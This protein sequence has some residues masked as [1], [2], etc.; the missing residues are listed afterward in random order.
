MNDLPQ[1][2]RPVQCSDL[3]PLEYYVKDDGEWSKNEISKMQSAI[4]KV[5][6]KQAEQLKEW[7]EK[8]SKIR[9][10]S[11]SLERFEKRFFRWFNAFQT[12]KFIHFL[13]D[14]CFLNKP[15]E[16][17]VPKLLE[18]LEIKKPWKGLLEE[19]RQLDRT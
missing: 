5:T 7:E 18:K 12:L 14:N 19:L 15:L 17:E 6:Q 4:G 11:T 16:T 8:L 9:S 2:D 1:E 3:K 10:Q 13:R